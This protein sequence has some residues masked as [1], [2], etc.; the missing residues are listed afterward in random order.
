MAM[1]NR[2]LWKETTLSI[3]TITLGLLSMFSFFD[4]IEELD[5][6][7]EGTYNLSNILTFV[8]L[9]I[10]GHIY[11]IA[12]VATLIGMMVSLGALGRTSELTIM[13]VSGLSITNLGVMLVKVGLLFT[14][15]TILIGE[16][17]TPVSE[18][19]AQ[20]MRLEATEGV[21]A[22]NFESGLWVKDEKS[23]INVKTALPDATLLDLSIYEFDENFK[24]LTISSAGKASYLDGRWRLSDVTQ[25]KIIETDQVSDKHVETTFFDKANWESGIRPELLNILLVEPEKISAWNLYSFITHLANNKQETNRYDVA[26][27]TKMIYPLACVV[28]VILALPFGFLQQRSSSTS[29]KIFI[30]ILLGVT[31]Q[32]MNRVFIHV[33][34]LND[35]PP[36]MSA[37]TP[38]ALFLLAGI[39]LLFITER[40]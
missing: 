27:W 18:E 8:L 21:V 7:G 29:A 16:F 32:I 2:Y 13:R 28:M 14:I 36:F 12:P 22:Q 37:I 15:A 34:V 6:L 25:T 19:A 40:R 39:Y 9:S 11:D 1:I 26:L 35:W 30:G 33:G 24:L 5:S 23:F 31:Y 4:L 3:L 17:I 38:T 20:R 10:P